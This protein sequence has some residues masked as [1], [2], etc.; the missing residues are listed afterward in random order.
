M[1]HVF[2]MPLSA[3]RADIVDCIRAQWSL[4]QIES[5]GEDMYLEDEDSVKS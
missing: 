2:C 4:Y 3:T 1:Q 5:I